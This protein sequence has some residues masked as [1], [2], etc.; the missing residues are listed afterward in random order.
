MNTEHITIIIV[1]WSIG[2]LI[3]WHLAY[4]EY[5]NPETRKNECEKYI[6]IG[7]A[8]PI[9]VAFILCLL[10]FASPVLIPLGI[11]AGIKHL[12]KKR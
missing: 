3:F 8:W 4:L 9:I 12:N 2:T 6:I 11:I 1:I 10:V 7:W 5:D